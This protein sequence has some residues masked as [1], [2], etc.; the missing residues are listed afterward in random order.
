MANF[1]FEA[2]H[3][4]TKLSK[5]D[6]KGRNWYKIAQLIED[7]NYSFSSLILGAHEAWF[8]SY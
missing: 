4:Q 7:K 3:R 6:K 2:F 8:F 5:M 1:L